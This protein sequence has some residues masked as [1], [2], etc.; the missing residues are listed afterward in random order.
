MQDMLRAHPEARSLA[1]RSPPSA[2]MEPP[3]FPN[4]SHIALARLRLVDRFQPERGERVGARRQLPQSH[5]SFK[6][7]RPRCRHSLKTWVAFI[8]STS[9]AQCGNVCSQNEYGLAETIHADVRQHS[10][11]APTVRTVKRLTP[12]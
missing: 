9:A 3:N 10:C 8:W 4:G 12:V 11:V 6:I 5:T 1:A 2:P 7:P